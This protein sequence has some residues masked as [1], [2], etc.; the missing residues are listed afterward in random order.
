MRLDVCDVTS[1]DQAGVAVL[2]GGARRAFREGRLLVLVDRD[3][4]VTKMV[5]MHLL[6]RFLI[7]QT[8]AA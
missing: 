7:T 8:W 6:G 1:I 3:G 2:I 5:R 4:S